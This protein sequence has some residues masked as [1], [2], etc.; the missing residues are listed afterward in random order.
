[1]V[2]CD[3]KSIYLLIFTLARWIFVDIDYRMVFFLRCIHSEGI[4]L[5]KN[6]LLV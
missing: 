1:M 3:D 4:K 6:I 2:R 5:D